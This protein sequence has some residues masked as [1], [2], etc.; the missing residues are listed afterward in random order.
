MP[1]R[2][3]KVYRVVLPCTPSQFGD[4]KFGL[5]KRYKHSASFNGE[6]TLEAVSMQCIHAVMNYLGIT[7]SVPMEIITYPN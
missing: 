5:L 6:L 4:L 2:A 3:R 7:W 1:S